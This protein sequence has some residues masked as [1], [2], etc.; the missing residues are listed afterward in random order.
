ME[1][2]MTADCGNVWTS[3]LNQVVYFL[4]RFFYFWFI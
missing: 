3:E 2:E 1:Q 4:F